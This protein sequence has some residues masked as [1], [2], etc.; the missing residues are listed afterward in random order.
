MKAF[1]TLAFKNKSLPVALDL[2]KLA[3]ALIDSGNTLEELK[4]YRSEAEWSYVWRDLERLQSQ[5]CP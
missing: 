3:P 4:E 5:R 1:L 2:E